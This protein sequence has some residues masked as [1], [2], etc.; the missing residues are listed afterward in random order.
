M[1]EDVEETRDVLEDLLKASG[2][3]VLSARNEE[4]ARLKSRDRKPDLILI[5]IGAPTSASIEAA[6]RIRL[7]AGVGE[8]LAIVVF[9]CVEIEEGSEVHLKG[10]VHLMRPDNFDQLRQLLRRLL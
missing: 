10:N 9:C 8:N 3:T 4:D 6:L 7:A 1:V 5:S 2:Y